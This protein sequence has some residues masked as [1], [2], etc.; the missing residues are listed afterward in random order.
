MKVDHS[1][2]GV[3]QYDAPLRGVSD[4]VIVDHPVF[5]A[6]AHE[7][8][9]GVVG[10]KSDRSDIEQCVPL[11]DDSDIKVLIP[12][13]FLDFGEGGDELGKLHGERPSVTTYFIPPFC[14][15]CQEDRHPV[16]MVRTFFWRGLSDRSL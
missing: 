1:S 7:D 15:S 3:A 13:L 9:I 10:V 11:V 2:N 5:V 14:V 8:S 6:G 4:V 16:G 12:A